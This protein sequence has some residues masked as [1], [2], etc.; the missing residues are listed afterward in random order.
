MVNPQ[1][2]RTHSHLGLT[3]PSDQSG[4]G[5]TDA[6]A[7]LPS[8]DNIARLFFSSLWPDRVRVGIH[9]RK[10]ERQFW[11]ISQAF[12]ATQV[13]AAPQI[14]PGNGTQGTHVTHPKAAT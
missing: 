1:R 5:R 11:N 14:K 12:E 3:T 7:I 9:P 8:S 13:S 6:L 10:L 4:E 2:T